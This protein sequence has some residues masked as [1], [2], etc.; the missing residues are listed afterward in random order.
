MQS[1]A[2]GPFSV[3]LEAFPLVRVGSPTGMWTE[4]DVVEFFACADQAVSRRARFVL[5]HDARGMPRL[6]EPQQRS[7]LEK[8][9]RR[10]TLIERFVLAYGAIAPSPLE[11]GVLTA[12]SWSTHL[13]MPR[14]IFATEAEATRYLRG[15]YARVAPRQR[16][17][18]EYTLQARASKREVG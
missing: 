4:R 3:D 13:A 18:G 6:T 15:V 5:L 10:H 17:S 16:I 12:L 8:L 2:G 11:R 14:R 1:R 7:F 9:L